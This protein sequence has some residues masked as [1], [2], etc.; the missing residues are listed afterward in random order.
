MAWHTETYM[1]AAWLAPYIINGDASSFDYYNTSDEE[2]KQ[3]DE[4]I[5]SVQQN[6]VGHWSVDAYETEFAMDE[7]SGLMADCLP[8]SWHWQDEDQD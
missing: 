2:I 4:W 8:F 1:I 6:R 5:E 3:I 7:I